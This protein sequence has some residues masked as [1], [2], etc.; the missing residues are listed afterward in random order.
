MDTQETTRTTHTE[1]AS[2]VNGS[3]NFYRWT[4]GILITIVIFVIGGMSGRITVS[5]EARQ[6]LEKVNMIE[7]VYGNRLDT[8]DKNLVD[9]KC[10]MKEYHD[11]NRELINRLSDYVINKKK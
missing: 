1:S 5:T 4:I 3:S 8:I 2:R 11:D 10:M 9:I 7:G 6:A